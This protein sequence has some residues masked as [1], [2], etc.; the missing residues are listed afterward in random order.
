MSKKNRKDENPEYDSMVVFERPLHIR[1]DENIVIPIYGLLYN[2]AVM[3]E[4]DL[5]SFKLHH[6]ITYLQGAEKASAQRVWLSPDKWIR[7]DGHDI[8]IS[9]PIK[10]LIYRLLRDKMIG[11]TL[12]EFPKPLEIEDGECEDRYIISETLLVRYLYPTYINKD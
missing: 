1:D 11:Y 9:T 6:F 5:F 10:N 3:H 12:L 2:K 7:P 4:E 8:P